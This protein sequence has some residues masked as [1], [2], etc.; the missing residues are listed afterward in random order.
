MGARHPGDDY[1][2]ALATAENALLISA[3]EHLLSLE[4]SPA[5]PLL[6]H[7]PT[8]FLELLEGRR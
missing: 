3:D 5:G 1:L 4:G 7:S 6:L 8:G 2:L